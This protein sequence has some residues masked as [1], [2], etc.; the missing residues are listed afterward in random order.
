MSSTA[1]IVNGLRQE[2]SEALLET[3]E[4]WLINDDVGKLLRA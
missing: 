4:S 2:K 3:R 1:D